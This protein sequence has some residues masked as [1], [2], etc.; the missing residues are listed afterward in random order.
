MKAIIEHLVVAVIALL[1]CDVGF[2][3]IGWHNGTGDMGVIPYEPVW[4]IQRYSVSILTWIYLYR[5]GREQHWLVLPKLGLISPFIGALLFIYPYFLWP[6]LTIWDHALVVFPTAI[7]CGVL[8]SICTL[9]FRPKANDLASCS[10][11][12]RAAL[13]WESR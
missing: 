10:P 3:A 2:W 5:I 11:G 12:L 1:M 6:W 7:A 8:V 4:T 13:P 9:P